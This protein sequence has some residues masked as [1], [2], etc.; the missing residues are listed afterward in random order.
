M[1]APPGAMPAHPEDGFADGDESNG[2][3]DE[4]LSSGI[5]EANSEDD[6]LCQ[7][8]SDGEKASGESPEL[9]A[10]A[11]AGI[12]AESQALVLGRVR[13]FHLSEAWKK[14][15]E[16]SKRDDYDYSRLPQVTGLGVHRHPSACFWSCRYPGEPWHTCR[17]NASKDEFICLVTILRHVIKCHVRTAPLDLHSWEAHLQKLQALRS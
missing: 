7:E 3:G 16:V 17:W 4:K 11:P 15:I 8:L 2:S 10:A 12:P 9:E 6:E 5:S 14:L 1:Q 13:K